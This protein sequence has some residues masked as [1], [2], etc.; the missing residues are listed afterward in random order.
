MLML[1]AKAV[2]VVIKNDGEVNGE[3]FSIP[4]VIIFI[5]NVDDENCP[6]PIEFNVNLDIY[7]LSV[8]YAPPTT[9]LY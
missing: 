3:I 7:A 2:E 6:F 8:L 5:D 4:L 1:I 9:S